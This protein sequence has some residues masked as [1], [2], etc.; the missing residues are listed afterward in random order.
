M[1]ASAGASPTGTS[2]LAH[3]SDSGLRRVPC[4]AH[5]IIVGS[6][7]REDTRGRRE[8]CCGRRRRS[9][10]HRM[11]IWARLAWGLAASGAWLVLAASACGTDAV[12]IESCRKVEEA[13][14]RQ[15]PGCNISLATPVHQGDD[16]EACIRYYD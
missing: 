9:T 4:P 8:S 6:T 2:G 13:R 14:C 10:S 12:G 15:A 16:V 7:S 3:Q 11:A 1:W 5:R